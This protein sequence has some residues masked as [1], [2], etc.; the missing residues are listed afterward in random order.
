MN[1]I[2]QRLLRNLLVGMVL[3]TSIAGILTHR[4]V[5]IELDELYNANLQQVARFMVSKLERNDLSTFDTTP[6]KPPTRI[7]WEEEDYLIQVW[8]R[9]GTLISQEVAAITHAQIPLDATQGFSRKD[10][11][12][13]SWRIYRAD[14]AHVI[15]QIAQPETARLSAIHEISAQLLGPLLLQVPLLI[16]VVWLSVRHG[17]IPLDLLSKVIAQRK[18]GALTAIDGTDQPREL[19]PL[20]AT[21]NELLAR[22]S[23]ALQQ[24]RNFVADAAHE[25]RTP[26]A[27]LQLQLDL[28]ERATEP[29]DRA[30]AIAQLHNGLQRT[31]HLIQQ[32]LSIARAESGSATP[33][34]QLVNLPSVIETTMERHLP[35]ARKRQLDLGVTRLESASISCARGDIESVLDNL[36]SN[37]IRYTP[38]GGRVDLALY[39][40]QLY[41]VIEITDS[42]LGIPPLERERIFDRFYRVLQKNV[43]EGVVEGSGL[44]LAIVKTICDRYQA[45]IQIDSGDNGKGTRFTVRWPLS[46]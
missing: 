22:L 4:H 6:Q 35:Y 40:D 32:L 44:G 31:T 28:L 46:T 26:I 20:I 43:D 15:V 8:S 25:L 10:I 2:R 16:L 17:V 29:A 18:P 1:S 30:Q 11:N 24:Q 3:I 12:G 13:E 37:A 27:A 34:L 23:A 42:G 9:E 14:G 7:A 5:R 41:A 45:I 21:L 36:V 39:C 38:Y 19:Q 33:F